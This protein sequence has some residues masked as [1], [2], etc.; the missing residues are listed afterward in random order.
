MVRLLA[1]VAAVASVLAFTAPS[2]AQDMVVGV[3]KSYEPSQR[4]VILEDGTRYML[5]EGVT[6][7][8][9]QPGM[10]VRYVFEER[11]GT[12]Y[13]TRITTVE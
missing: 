4:I 13:I 10:R 8:Q 5:S 9:Y 2:F 1:S 12:R 3:I 6:I 11:G 7:Q